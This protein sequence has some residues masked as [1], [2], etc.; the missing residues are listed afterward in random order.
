MTKR[1]FTIVVP[2]KPREKKMVTKTVTGWASVFEDGSVSVWA[3]KNNADCYL[4]GRIACVK[5]TGEYEVE[6]D[7]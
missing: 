2:E 1:N 5:L 7:A 4:A 3:K 6:E